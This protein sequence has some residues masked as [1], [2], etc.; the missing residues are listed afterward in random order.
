VTFDQ[1]CRAYDDLVQRLVAI[2]AEHPL[3]DRVAIVGANFE[4]EATQA[5]G[6]LRRAIGGA[7]WLDVE[8][9]IT[10]GCL[11]SLRLFRE[12]GG[13]RE[14]F[15][16]YFVDSEYCWRARAAGYRVIQSREP[17][18]L[19]RT[20]TTTKHQIFN[21][22]YTTAHYA[23]WRHYYIVRNGFLLA[24]AEWKTDRAWAIKW[25]RSVARRSAIALFFEE[26]KVE[27]LRYML[28]GTVDAVRG[29]AGKLARDGPG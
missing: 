27:K 26:D 12:L 17:L 29:R 10:S 15:F 3:R 19:H 23:P 13:Y 14:D 9:V 28:R 22:Q 5:S 20:G 6:Y 24:R 8:D 2:R 4:E 1:D 7:T 18:F 25:A 16:I 21:R 11:Q